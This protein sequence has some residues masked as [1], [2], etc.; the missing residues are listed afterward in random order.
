MIDFAK[1]IKEYRKRKFLTQEEFAKIIGVSV[2]SVNRWEN[3]K[4]EPTMQLKKK[5]YQLFIEAGMKVEE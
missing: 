3:G 1:K 4:F 5:L 2:L